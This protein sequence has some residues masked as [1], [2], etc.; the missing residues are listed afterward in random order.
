MFLNLQSTYQR[1]AGSPAAA[2]PE[3]IPVV[4]TAQ[5]QCHSLIRRACIS[6]YSWTHKYLCTPVRSS[7]KL[8]AT[9]TEPVTCT[10]HQCNMHSTLT[11]TPHLQPACHSS[12]GKPTERLPMR[13]QPKHSADTAMSS[14]HPAHC[15]C[16]GRSIPL[17]PFRLASPVQAAQSC[18]CATQGL[19][20]GT[21]CANLPTRASQVAPDN[22]QR[23]QLISPDQAPQPASRKPASYSYATGTC[24]T[25]GL[26]VRP[27]TGARA[28][29]E[30]CSTPP[31]LLARR[32]TRAG[33]PCAARWPGAR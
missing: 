28:P 12:K 33:A 26:L 5:H 14:P 10:L 29:A 18:A 2:E 9:I 27:S 21:A 31:R 25:S 7:G 6:G 23:W 16:S 8:S 15:L 3:L 20:K 24:T 1:T 22:C 19:P 13:Q 32:L 30:P 4:H 11:S 17:P